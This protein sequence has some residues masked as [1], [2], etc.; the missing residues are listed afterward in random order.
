[1]LPKGVFPIPNATPT[2]CHYQRGPR[3]ARVCLQ[4]ADRVGENVKSS[5]RARCLTRV[6]ERGDAR[7]TPNADV[8]YGG[9]TKLPSGRPSKKH[10][11]I[12]AATRRRAF[13]DGQI[14]T[15]RV[16]R[17]ERTVPPVRKVLETTSKVRRNATL[18][19][20]Q[21]VIACGPLMAC[22]F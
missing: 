16:L 13:L 2:L 10:G 7:E 18:E 15:R 19:I 3:N 1:M 12:F 21:T 8:S 11:R 20:H 6:G 9:K 14:R 17:R 22:L 5:A 4:M